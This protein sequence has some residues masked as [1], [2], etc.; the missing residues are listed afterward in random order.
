MRFNARKHSEHLEN[1][2]HQLNKWLEGDARVSGAV[3]S[4]CCTHKRRH[5]SC[6]D[7]TATTLQRRA[8]EAGDTFLGAAAL[9]VFCCAAGFCASRRVTGQTFGSGV[10]LPNHSP[11][12]FLVCASQVRKTPDG[13]RASAQPRRQSKVCVGPGVETPSRSTKV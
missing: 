11:A 12:H 1:F 5:L 7:I 4:S 10:S 13:R 2:N 8:S 9:F 6:A 3:R